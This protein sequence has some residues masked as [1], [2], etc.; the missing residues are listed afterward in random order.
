MIYFNFCIY[1]IYNIFK[2]PINS[3]FSSLNFSINLSRDWIVYN[4]GSSI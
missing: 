3:F 1:F 4:T 2:A